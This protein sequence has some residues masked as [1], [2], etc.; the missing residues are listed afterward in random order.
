MRD[1][2]DGLRADVAVRVAGALSCVVAYVAIKAL[3]HFDA[4]AIQAVLAAIAFLCGSFGAALMW[5]GHHI[6]DRVEVS[7]QWRRRRPTPPVERR[8]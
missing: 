6:F 1:R 4:D 7:D 5:L 2:H 3:G 8:L